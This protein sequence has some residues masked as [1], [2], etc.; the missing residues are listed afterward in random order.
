M[1]D[2]ERLLDEGSEFERLLLEGGI[3]ERPNASLTRRMALGAGLGGALSY[4]SSAKAWMQTWWGK[5]V[6]F[7]SVGVGLLGAIAIG[8]QPSRAPERDVPK[9][10]LVSTPTEPASPARSHRISADGASEELA[11][12]KGPTPS[13]AIEPGA[14]TSKRRTSAKPG[15][16]LAQEIKVLDRVRGL[17]AQGDSAAALVALDGYDRRF[18]EGTLGREARVLRARAT[19]ER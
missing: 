14:V 10:P 11:A 18:P 3:A 4:T 15:S 6:V 17:M 19:Q 13:P 2:P 8:A 5:T 12:S 7:A 9:A 1:Q 16:T